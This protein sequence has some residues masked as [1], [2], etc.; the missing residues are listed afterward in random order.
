MLFFVNP[1]CTIELKSSIPWTFSGSEEDSSRCLGFVL[2]SHWTW[3]TW[4]EDQA[5]ACGTQLTTLSMGIVRTFDRRTVRHDDADLYNFYSD[6]S[7]S[8]IV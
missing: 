7:E 3:L 4:T 2:G 1:I 8:A 6:F 5:T